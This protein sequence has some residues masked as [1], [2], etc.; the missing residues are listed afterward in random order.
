MRLMIALLAVVLLAATNGSLWAGEEPAT[1]APAEAAPAAPAIKF[2]FTLGNAAAATSAG[3]FDAADR[4]VR[5]VWAM[6]PLPAGLQTGE[7]DGLDEFGKPAPA[8]EY[9]FRVVASNATYKNVAVIGN[10]GTD[11]LQHIQHGMAQVALDSQGRVYTA[12]GWEEG[13]QDFKVMD[14]GGKTL[15]HARYQMRNGNPN[16]APHAITVDEN[17][18]YCGMQGWAGDQW[19]SRAQIQRF[20]IE[21]DPANPKS[22]PGTLEKFTDP[23]LEQYAGHIQLYEFPEKLVPPG[24]PE[25]D[26]ALMRFPVRALAIGGDTIFACDALGGKIVKYHKVTGTKQGDF[27]VKLPHAIAIDS[28]GRL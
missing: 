15:F 14:T 21:A 25:E 10:T 11:E 28:T 27:P 4:L 24:T 19:K 23:A 16:G 8:G 2:E 1:A 20:K 22:L 12:N 13:G 9:E 3:I 7:W 17:Y 5:Q 18:I 26:A 6:K